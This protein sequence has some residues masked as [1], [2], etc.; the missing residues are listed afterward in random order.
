MVIA[1]GSTG[2][3]KL[4]LQAG[5]REARILNRAVNLRGQQI[6]RSSWSVFASVLTAYKHRME[7]SSNQPLGAASPTG[8]LR[9]WADVIIVGVLLL[10]NAG[11]GFW[12]ERPPTS[13]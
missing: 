6:A 3:V 13:G 2:V 1:T 4:S 7:D 5:A 10:F 8:A 11:V 9:H 12:P